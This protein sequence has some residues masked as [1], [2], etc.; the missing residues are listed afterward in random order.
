MLAG[1][2]F[3]LYLAFGY[4]AVNPLAQRL[5]PWVGDNLLASRLTV[6]EV[7]FDP[8]SLELTVNE[9]RLSRRDGGALAGFGRLVVD[10]QAD[11]LFRF[12]WHLRDIVIT[13][14]EVRVETGKDGRL[15]WAELL[16][17]LNKDSQPS[18]TMPRVVIDRLR[19]ADGRVQYAELNRAQPFHTALSPLALELGHF[20]TLPE[21][22]GDYQV[23][24]DLAG[25]GGKLR[26]KGNLGVNPLASAGAIDVQ[27][28]KLASLLALARQPDLPLTLSGGE[29]GVRVDYD[30][31]LV[32]GKKAPFPQLRLRQL[33]VTVA[34]LEGALNPRTSL[35]LQSLR[36][37]LPDLRLQLDD[38][39]QLQVAPFDVSA[40][41]LQLR[42]GDAPLFVL[43]Q[44]EI[45]Q[46]A[47][48]ATERRLGIGRVTMKEGAL[49]ATRAKDGTLDWL[50]ALP[51]ATAGDPAPAKADAKTDA[52]TDAKASAKASAKPAA[53][54]PASRPFRVELAE[55]RI[56]GWKL[57]LHDQSFV[58]PLH[59]AIGRI[60]A[61]LRASIGEDGLRVA[62]LSAE[63]GAL[64]LQADG[65]RQPLATLARIALAGGELDLQ[66]RSASLSELSV[67][68]LQTSVVRQADQTLNWQA[69][70]QPA[71]TPAR[72][73]PPAA[74]AAPTGADWRL[75][76]ERLRLDKLNLHV[77]D[78]S[79]LQPM[80]VD[81]QDAALDARGVSLDPRRP[82]ALTAKLALRQGGQLDVRGKL[83]AA[84]LRGDLQMALTGLQ[85][86]PY[87][88]YLSQFVMVNLTRGQAALKGKLSFSAAKAFSA[89][90]NGGFDVSALEIAKE[91]DGTAF[92]SWDTLAS[93]SLSV[94]LAPNRV[95]LNELRIVHPTA[96]LIIHEDKTI[97][98]Q[99]LLRPP[100]AAAPAKPAVIAAAAPVK[101]NAAAAPAGSGDFSLALERIRVADADLEFADLSLRP[102]F[103]AH[104]H[105]LNGVINGLSTD[106]AAVA[107]VELDGKVDDYGSARVRG[108][109]QP[110]RATEFTDLKVEFRN[111]EMNRLTPYS[112]KFAGRKIDA[113]KLSVDLEYRLKQRQLI[114]ENKV[115]LNNIRLGERV[116]SREAMNLPLDLAIAILEDSDGV[117]DLDLPVTG[118]LDD[119]KFSYGAII[120]KAIV[121]VVQKI[122]TAPFRAIGKMLGISA[123]KLEAIA[124]DPGSAALAPPE[125]EK[126]ASVAGALA[127][128]PALQLQLVP[129]FDPAAD[130]AALQ[131]LATR[132]DVAAEL[133][134]K[135]AAGEPI[136]PI[137]LA[138][139]K[140][141]TAIDNLLKDRSG[142]KRNLKVLDSVKDYFR[143]TKPEDLPAYAAQLEKLKATV[144]VGDPELAALAG[145]RAQAVRA[146]L[147]S[148][149]GLDGARVSIGEPVMAKGDGKSVGL[150]M[151][152]GAG[153]TR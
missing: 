47:F 3:V 28:L 129:A 103:G 58:Q 122:V 85:L 101:A 51:V 69:V 93:D 125:Q 24:A 120:W 150:T 139:V 63:L 141:Q 60:D 9:L 114:G 123:D 13:R 84:P 91:S 74:P 55:L 18:G 147:T 21:D 126:L 19:I 89:R 67:S 82:M 14:P 42:Q 127:K 53:S 35:A 16:A 27:G 86:K 134:M 142:Q 38:Q 138:N 151:A 57:A 132:R 10:L 52:K 23:A 54:A 96:R 97:N 41:G 118:S 88:P 36:T 106:P 124:F 131:E 128:R 26:W 81:V 33:G 109:V 94:S 39:A 133:G 108:S 98:L 95:Q 78:R 32:A 100:P 11:S 80:A 66:G 73:A 77:E 144:K 70:L 72:A 152:L 75:A 110:F 153:G 71:Q 15:N 65:Q 46:L 104:I 119:P 30:F 12:A 45:Q 149:G 40:S 79:L 121:N 1:G 48:D 117:I 83:S 115:V 61:G 62:A 64:S 136:G 111:L 148:A 140:V 105:Y 113:G 44:A 90:F 92:L 137:D 2:L 130:K 68:G 17:A 87:S 5:L 7:R 34:N 146:Y 37:T 20:S 50:Q 116:D 49:Q 59:A 43:P 56:E 8:L 6:G 107:Q 145:A 76:L 143:K 112:G 4:L 22:R 25:I 31:A 99:R 102:Q 29:L 135:L